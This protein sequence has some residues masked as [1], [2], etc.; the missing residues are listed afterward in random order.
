MKLLTIFRKKSFWI[1][2]FI[3]AAVAGGV[4]YQ[5]QKNSQPIYTTELVKRQKLIQTVSATGTVEAAEEV[6][7]NFKTPG[8][9][10]ELKVK[11]GDRV[12]AGQT[13]AA[14]DSR[15]AQS[16]VLTAE[17][18]LKSAQ[19][20]LDK[21]KAGVSPAELA[22]YEAA[23]KTAEI[24]LANIIAS[25][26]R[27]VANARAQLLGLP[28]A[29]V[30]NPG[31]LSTATLTVSGTY[32]GD[33]AG[34]YIVRIEDTSQPIFSYFGLEEGVNQSGSRT[35][36]VPLGKLGLSIQFSASGSLFVN[37]SW[38]INIPNTNHSGYAAAMS[39]Y[40]ASVVTQKQQVEA[41]ERVLAEAKLKLE[42]VKSPPRSYDLLAA[43]AAVESAQ[44][45]LAKAQSDLSDRFLIAPLNGIITSVNNKIG[46]T[47]SP[48]QPV[49]VLLAD[50]N[51][52]IK[53]QVPEADIVKLAVGQ[54]ADIT[55]DALGSTEHFIGHISF[56][57]PASTV[58]QDVVYY[59]VTVLFGQADERLKPGMTANVE[60][61]T[62]S[63]D[64]VLTIPWR[65]VKY[66]ESHQP[67]VEVLRDDEVVIKEVK[68][69]L[70]GDLGVVEV[71]EGLN[72]GEKVITFKQGTK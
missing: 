16:A 12:T 21:L 3:I 31:N 38:V 25:Q 56:I 48:S 67:Y 68:I 7:L 17:A 34:S 40:E 2:F 43:E 22:V 62:A 64:N 30:A 66:N 8:R 28:A 60:V 13:L 32:H 15:D 19:A 61:V 58:I 11:V 1:I 18:N 63:K 4:L 23:V 42:Q 39:A 51:K 27:A 49:L 29:A 26:E 24:N 33:K 10:V 37:D 69:G 44:A 52:E 53:V 71:I 6:K 59:E 14:L 46:E 57:D 55:L 65:S 45:A 35:T 47:T 36:A 54:K 50:S 9:L 41:A 20:A 72:E 70:R 5:R